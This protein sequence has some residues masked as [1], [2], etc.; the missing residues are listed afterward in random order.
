MNK[1]KKAAALTA[2]VLLSAVVFINA[3][4]AASYTVVQ[5]NSLYKIGALFGTTAGTIMKD[6]NL[7]SGTIYPGSKPWELFIWI[8]AHKNKIKVGICGEMA[9]DPV[10]TL[11]ACVIAKELAAKQP[12][13]TDCLAVFCAYLNSFARASKAGCEFLMTLAFTQYT[14]LK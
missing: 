10:A 5:N 8:N 12:Y 6:N 7:S 4:F 9:S 13:P 11:L 3:V 2:G 14:T 1:I